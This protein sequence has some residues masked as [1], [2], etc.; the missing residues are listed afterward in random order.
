MSDKSIIQAAMADL[1]KERVILDK[2][3]YELVK[4]L[5]NKEFKG[6]QEELELADELEELTELRIE[7]TYAMTDL[8][9][10]L[11]VIEDIEEQGEQGI[12]TWHG[13]HNTSKWDNLDCLDV[14]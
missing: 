9:D 7:N 5:D 13:I 4:I 2:R 12:D 10:Q 6:E 11:G 8:I 14:E 1:A 3:Y